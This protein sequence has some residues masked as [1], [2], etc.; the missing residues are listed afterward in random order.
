M[1]WPRRE[2]A[3]SHRAKLAPQS[4][5]RHGKRE[6]IPDPLRQISKPPPERVEGAQRRVPQGS[7]QPRLV[8]QAGRT[9]HRS[10]SRLAPAPFWPSSGHACVLQDHRAAF[11]E[12]QHPVAHDQQR[13]PGNFRRSTPAPTVKDQS[14]G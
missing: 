5:A 12:P 13:Y 3:I 14:H 1:A 7:V 9:A 4:V 10:G 6:L 8:L 11:I 2:L